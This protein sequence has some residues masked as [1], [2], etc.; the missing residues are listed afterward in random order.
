MTKP[1]SPVTDQTHIEV[2][3]KVARCEAVRAERIIIGWP[4]PPEI[5]VFATP[6]LPRASFE[7]SHRW[8]ST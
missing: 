8:W 1:I 7:P 5:G 2:D 6:P 4:K 3:A